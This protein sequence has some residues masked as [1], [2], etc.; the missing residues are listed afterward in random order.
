MVQI[1]N[2]SRALIKIET[3]EGLHGWGE[4]YSI[5]PDLAAEPIANYIFELIKGEDPRRIEYL[6]LKLHQQFRFPIGGVGLAVISAVDHALWDISGKAAGLPTYMLLGGSVRDRVEVYLHLGGKS[7]K[8]AADHAGRLN[9]NWGVTVF[10]TSPYRIDMLANRW[11]MVCATAA[12]FFRTCV[13]IRRVI[14]NL[15]LMLTQKFSSQFAHYN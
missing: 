14:G 4:A 12:S 1:N 9:E 2:R 8:E 5:G 10:K 15:L 11:G 7:G 3:N 6:M 13:S